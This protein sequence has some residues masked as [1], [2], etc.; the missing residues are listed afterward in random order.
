MDDI[1]IKISELYTDEIFKIIHHTLLAMKN[2]ENNYMHYADGLN[3]ILQPVNV[4][5]KK[6]IDENIVF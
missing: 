1:F 6:W 4:R 2:D 5:I 3:M